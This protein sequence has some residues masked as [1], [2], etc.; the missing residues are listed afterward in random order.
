MTS[1][2][3]D[4][5]K[6]L[7]HHRRHL[8]EDLRSAPSGLAWCYKHTEIADRVVQLLF[9]DLMADRPELPPIALIATGGYGRRE[10]SPYSDIDLTIVPLEE[11]SA[12][13]EGAI[14]TLFQDLHHAFGTDIRMEVGYAYRLISDAPGIDA[15]TRTGLLDARLLCGSADLYN[16]LLTAL[17]EHFAVGEFVLNKIEE[18]SEAYRRYHDTPFVSELHLKEGA[19]GLRD[20]HCAN[21]LREA[22]GE[23][24][25]QPSPDLDYLTLQRNLLHLVGDRRLDTLSR[26]RQAEVAAILGKSAREMMSD[27]VGAAATIHQGYL[28]ACEHLTEARF[29]LSEGVLAVRGEARILSGAEAGEAAVGIAIAT[30]LGLRVPDLQPPAGEIANGPAALY[31]I[32]TGEA[33]I[34]NLDRAGLLARLLPELTECHTL[35]SDDSVHIY[36]VFEHTLRV[37]RNL[38]RLHQGEFLGDL[39]NSLVDLEPLYLAALLHDVG[40]ADHHREHSIVG[41]EIAKAVGERWAIA[42]GTRELVEWLVKEHLTMARFIRIR[43]IQNPTTVRE[44]ARLVGSLERLQ[45]LTLLTWADVNAVAPNA[46]TPSQETFLKELY[47]ATAESLEGDGDGEFDTSLFRQ[48]LLRQLKGEELSEEKVQA[49]IQSL[50]A[51]YLTSTSTD[52]IRLHLRFAEKAATG[53]PTIEVYQRPELGATD[54]TVCVLDRPALLSHLLGVFYAYDL[55]VAGIRACTTSTEPRVALDVFTVSFGGR[56]VPTATLRHVNDALLKVFSGERKVEDILR[57]KG[58]DPDRTQVVYRHTFLAG[59][60][61]I[62]EVRAPRGRG[63]AYRFSRLIAAQGWNVVAARFGQWAGQAAAAFYLE[64]AEQELDADRVAQVLAGPTT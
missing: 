13:L 44:F 56:P 22:S 8:I 43:D 20:W 27:V 24:P 2:T 58:K 19:G 46:W 1:E 55:S 37:V 50:P 41:A 28:D 57:E 25:Y 64:A 6:S 3:Q 47:R 62:L 4:H 10:L 33:T 30:R 21:W 31:A 48:R 63:M 45:M 12:A 40:K 26:T 15:K 34:R 14:R 16:R 11:E 7:A 35:L 61:A 49:F 42:S 38:D 32:S 52:I 17:S 51:H 29:T 54:L 53:T 39:K 60:P 9:Q 5:I 23:K 59:S 36:T 18:R